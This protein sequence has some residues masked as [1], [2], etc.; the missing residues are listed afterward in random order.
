MGLAVSL[1]TLRTYGHFT[2][3]AATSMGTSFSLPTIGRS[4]N[5]SG[6]IIWVAFQWRDVAGGA[7]EKIRAIE[8][9]DSN[10][11]AA[12]NILVDCYNDPVAIASKHVR[13]LLECPTA[14]KESPEA[15]M[16]TS[17]ALVANYKAL[18][19]LKI[20]FAEAFPVYA[21][22]FQLG[23]QTHYVWESQR[24]ERT[25]LTVDELA[26]F[27]RVRSQALK[28][29]Q[30]AKGLRGAGKTKSDSR[31]RPPARNMHS[32]YFSQANFQ[33]NKT[34][35]Y[36]SRI[37]TK[38]HLCKS[39]H[40]ILSCERLAGAAPEDRIKIVEAAGLCTNCLRANHKTNVCLLGPC[41]K[42]RAKHHTMLHVD[43]SVAT[44]KQ[45]AHIK[46]NKY[47]TPALLSTAV[48]S[49]LGC[50]GK[51]HECQALLDTRAESHFLTIK[52]ANK[53]RIP[54]REVD[55]PISGIN[56]T[57]TRAKQ[58]VVASIASRVEDYTVAVQFLLL[59]KITEA[60]PSRKIV[61]EKLSV[62]ANIQLADPGFDNPGEIDAILG[63]GVFYTLLR[64]GQ[65]ILDDSSLI[66]QNTKLGWIGAPNDT[67]QVTRAVRCHTAVGSLHEQL[68]KFWRVEQA[69]ENNIISREEELCEK[70]YANN[71]WRDESGKY[72]VRLTFRENVNQVGRSYTHA[73]KRLHALKGPLARKPAIREQYAEF[74]S[75]Y[76]ALGHMERVDVPLRDDG[77]YLPHHAVTKQSSHTTKLRVVFDASAKTSTD[78]SL[79]NVLMVGPTIQDDL[80]TI[81][82]RFRSHAI[83]LTADIAKMYRQIL[84]DPRDRKYQ[85]I[86]WRYGKSE[87]IQTYRLNTVTY[88]TASASFLATHT[89]HQLANDEARWFP[90]ASVILKEDFYVDDLLTGARTV[91]EATQIRDELS[92]LTSREGMQL[93]QWDSNC[94]ELIE[95]F[96]DACSDVLIR[97]DISNTIKTLGINW[98]AKRDTISYKVRQ[99]INSGEISKRVILS[100]ITQL[101]D[102]LGLLGPVIISAK[103]MMQELWQLKSSWDEGVPEN[104]KNAWQAFRRDLLSSENI[105]F[106]RKITNDNA[107][108]E[109]HGFCDASERA[110]G[111]CIYARTSGKENSV[112]LICAKSRVA[113]LKTQSLPRLELCGALL[114]ARL[115]KAVRNALRRIK[116]NRVVFWSDS[117]IT[118]HW[119]NTSPHTLKTFV[120]HRVAEIQEATA[121]EQWRHVASE[122]N[123]ADLISRGVAASE[124]VEN[125][126]WRSG[127]PWLRESEQYWPSSVLEPIQIPEIKNVLVLTASS[128]SF[129]L[130]RRY[131][132]INKLKRVIARCFRFVRNASNCRE[133]RTKGELTVE[134]LKKAEIAIIKSVQ[135]EAF[136]DAI[137]Q[138]ESG[139]GASASMVE[140]SPFLDDQGILRVGG[141]LAKSDLSYDQN[142]AAVLPKNHFT[143]DLIIREN[144]VRVGHGG[145]QATLNAV[146]EAFW[147]LNGRTSVK[148][149]IGRCV[150]CRRAKPTIPVYRIS[151]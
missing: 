116:L 70:H 56:G 136:A 108:L 95:G 127:P 23:E 143:T 78:L 4:S 107:N 93:R 74:L 2:E 125:E 21:V 91:A 45:C 120:A 90:R 66:L 75:E 82:V 29:S 41:K 89:L 71:T 52:L 98:N 84:V 117:T 47:T 77:C 28:N 36:S 11:I 134:E 102:P 83:A 31:N 20:P 17:D 43:G 151:D 48:L 99:S 118:L 138:T 46:F 129:N 94:P 104:I 7:V 112:Q 122:H 145:A 148:R 19:T 85:Q 109:L 92:E 33:K 141:R 137:K 103:M 14:S 96:G 65:V 68:E 110:Y 149:V 35:V 72:V 60:L 44:A 63:I 16:A 111:T 37:K 30:P 10:Y 119:I 69:P 73:L 124:L 87:P 79:N 146:R 32:R 133:S 76:L 144:H 22:V 55:V 26:K 62:P 8:T 9:T 12:W 115:Y 106:A 5:S 38:C 50:D 25:L 88:G 130:L 147:P 64:S 113:P 80:F 86:L 51:P 128:E 61:A 49:V 39:E 42:C 1:K 34:H 123:P 6:Y 67:R 105:Q 121:S 131:S 135:R 101:F 24:R 97:L 126:L 59:P 58:A 13:A 15:L 140:L 57:G 3:L 27:L 53:L 40:H 150:I 54:G 142:H 100:E 139:R 18:E 132:S 114:L 81:L